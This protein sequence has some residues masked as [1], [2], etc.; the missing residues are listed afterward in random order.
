VLNQG[1]EF[2]LHSVNSRMCREQF[3][4]CVSDILE[5]NDYC[6]CPFCSTKYGNPNSRLI[7]IHMHRHRWKW[8]W[9]TAF[10]S[11]FVTGK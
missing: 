3:H 7:H 9:T 10:L 11:N 1:R 2:Q 8:P 6:E 5:E 4:A